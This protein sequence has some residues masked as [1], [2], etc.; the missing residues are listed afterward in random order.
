M[1]NQTELKQV[2]DTLKSQCDDS[3]VIDTSIK[4]RVN[5]LCD[6]L[7]LW[8]VIGD[9]GRRYNAEHMQTAVELMQL[10]RNC[11]K[12]LLNILSLPSIQTV[13]SYLG[14]LGNP[15]CL[16][17]IK[18][19]VLLL[20]TRFTL[21]LRCSFK[22]T[23]YL[24]A[25]FKTHEKK[26]CSKL[27]LETYEDLRHS[28]LRRFD[29]CFFKAFGNNINDKL[30]EFHKYKVLLPLRE[31][32]LTYHTKVTFFAFWYQFGGNIPQNSMFDPRL[33]PKMALVGAKHSKYLC[34]DHQ[35]TR[36]GIG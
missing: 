25:V 5:F 35:H 22:R 27:F 29:N 11:Y 7:K 34:R 18:N 33:S 8:F 24:F 13:K 28:I 17:G 23:K 4:R 3:D 12:A 30:K 2:A 6:Q 31:C 36:S 10:S 16:G 32:C 19:I 9:N 21:N 20:L 14:K 15:E 1:N 26:C